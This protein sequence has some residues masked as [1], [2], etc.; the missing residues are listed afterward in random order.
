[1]TDDK[2][3]YALYFDAK[4][5]GPA[6]LSLQLRDFPPISERDE[7]HLGMQFKAEEL[8][9]IAIP[10]DGGLY[11][12]RSD[13][14]T[15]RT[16]IG[17]WLDANPPDPPGRVADSNRCNVIDHVTNAPCTGPRP[18]PIHNSQG[19]RA[20]HGDG[21]S[22]IWAIGE[23]G[24]DNDTSAAWTGALG[25]DVAMLV[26]AGVKPSVIAAIWLDLT[27]V[28]RRWERRDLKGPM[29]AVLGGEGWFIHGGDRDHGPR[30][31]WT[32]NVDLA[33]RFETMDEIPDYLE[34]LDLFHPDHP[35]NLE[36]VGLRIVRV[37]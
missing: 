35:K 6:P 7:P 37:L 31:F 22:E 11:M 13:A 29:Y 15:L 5:C 19:W 12:G 16:E 20:K 2:K 1:M 21:Q 14:A 26:N 9:M 25:F 17:V 28:W 32:D 10:A 36:R 23:V 34:P 24:G 3:I 30:G 27:A 8:T 33:Q 18:C 4:G